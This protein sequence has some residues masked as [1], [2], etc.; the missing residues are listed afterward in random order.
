MYE[1]TDGGVTWT[2]QK[3]TK[4]QLH[5][6]TDLVMDPHEPGHLFASFWGDEI[7]KSTDGGATWA[8]P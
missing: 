8:T 7:Y 4:N 5:G 1:S 2:L 6:A 3:G